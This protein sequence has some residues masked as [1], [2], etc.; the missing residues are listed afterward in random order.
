MRGL[1]GPAFR[2][3]VPSTRLSSEASAFVGPHRPDRAKDEEEEKKPAAHNPT[4]R[5]G[6]ADGATAIRIA[7]R[8]GCGSQRH[9]VRQR[10]AR[11]RRAKS[12]S[13]AITKLAVVGSASTAPVALDCGEAWARDPAKAEP[14]GNEVFTRPRDH[15]PVAVDILVSGCRAIAPDAPPCACL[16]LSVSAKRN[17]PVGA[18]PSSPQTQAGIN[19]LVAAHRARLRR[20]LDGR[21]TR[22]FG[23]SSFAMDAPDG[24][25]A[26][27]L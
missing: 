16:G 24:S 6:C 5:N 7:R 15:H 18:G 3:I 13:G 21:A 8:T 10:K 11:A 19:P 25:D 4:P 2:H 22:N 12:R 27:I 26:C 20:S 1:L 17:G 23:C 9:V 14:C